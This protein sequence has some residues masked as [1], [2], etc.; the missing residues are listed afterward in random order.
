[1]NVVETERS[2]YT[3]SRHMRFQSA[4]ENV[5]ASSIEVGQQFLRSRS[6]RA[7]DARERRH[8]AQERLKQ[9]CPGT[10]HTRAERFGGGLVCFFEQ[11]F[12][13]GEGLCILVG[14]ANGSSHCDG[15]QLPS[16]WVSCACRVGARLSMRG[17]RRSRTRTRGVP[18]LAIHLHGMLASAGDSN[19]AA[20]PPRHA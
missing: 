3:Y 18:L 6:V 11:L 13:E 20:P 15:R 10:D 14:G 9:A 8:V 19:A 17:T 1:M 12:L 7:E 5:S 16:T 2:Y 4:M